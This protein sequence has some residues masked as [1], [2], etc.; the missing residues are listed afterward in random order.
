LACKGC[1]PMRPWCARWP[2]LALSPVRT[3]PLP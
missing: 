3:S 2:C 1:G